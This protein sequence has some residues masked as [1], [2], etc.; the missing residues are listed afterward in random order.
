MVLSL[1]PESRVDIKDRA[2]IAL[3]SNVIQDAWD[4]DVFDAARCAKELEFS[5]ALPQAGAT[6]NV[7]ANAGSI[8]ADLRSAGAAFAK[9]FNEIYSETSRYLNDGEQ[10]EV[11]FIKGHAAPRVL[12]AE[13]DGDSL[14]LQ[15]HHDFGLNI[16]AL[17]QS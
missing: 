12:S 1:N 15:V 10:V 6:A 5:D 17:T 16:A 9:R 4:D 8:V 13:W 11:V 3:C 14:T 7:V 2:L